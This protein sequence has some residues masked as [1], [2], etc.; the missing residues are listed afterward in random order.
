MWWWIIII[1]KGT[2]IKNGIRERRGKIKG[3]IKIWII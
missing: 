3:L 2:K 1:I